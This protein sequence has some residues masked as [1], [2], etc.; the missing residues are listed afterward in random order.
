MTITEIEALGALD[1]ALSQLEPDAA[2]R[3]LRW[4]GAKYGAPEIVKP[5]PDPDDEAGG[6]DNPAV[7]FEEMADLMAAATPKTGVE[8]VLIATYWFQVLSGESNVNSQ[9]INNELK[10]L[11]YPI[12]NITDTFT[13]LMTRKPQLAMQVQK[14]GTSRQARKKYKLTIEGINAVKRMLV[15]TVD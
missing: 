14:S 12:S 7:G 4:A 9:Q 10:N 6:E 3:V 2:V 15:P 8:R 1:N 11:G 5:E 13:S